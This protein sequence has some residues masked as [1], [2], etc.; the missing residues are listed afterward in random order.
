MT[1]VRVANE[2]DA[3]AIA[4][5]YAPIVR[6]TPI[7]FEIEP[8]DASEFAD[9]IAKTLA[10]YPWLV[11]EDDDGVA[12]YAYASAHRTRA[13][14][15]W[16]CDVSVYVAPRRKRCG[17]GR[18]LYDRLFEALKAQGL[19]RAYAGITLPNDGSV[20]LHEAAGFRHIGVYEG[21]GFKHGQWW[22]VGWWGL[23][24]SE[25]RS[26]PADP[27]PFGEVRSALEF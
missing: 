22:P 3:Q 23:A 24:L 8:P 13:A 9:R 7:S 6:E 1:F 10:F 25:K 27:I 12:G 2:G 4:D 15:R 11:A 14:Y 18:R 19:M 26:A 20:R 5:I 17:I 21:V 16:S